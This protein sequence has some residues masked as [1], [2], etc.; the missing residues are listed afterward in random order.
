[1]FPA[2]VPGGELGIRF[3]IWAGACQEPASLAA[4]LWSA[5]PHGNGWVWTPE[6]VPAL[7]PRL[8]LGALT[9]RTWGAGKGWGP[10]RGQFQTDN[11]FGEHA[12]LPSLGLRGLQG[13]AVGEGQD[14]S[15]SWSRVSHGRSWEARPGTETPSQV[16]N[17]RGLWMCGGKSQTTALKGP[18]AQPFEEEHPSTLSPLLSS[19]TLEDNVRV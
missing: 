19:G 2:R 13:E 14:P 10:R 11:V 4:W 3:P 16:I 12:E 6:R 17:P 9:Q 5:W 18:Q 8:G 15:G 7:A 1:M